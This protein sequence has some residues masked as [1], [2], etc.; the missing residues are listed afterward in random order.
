MAMYLNDRLIDVGW[1]NADLLVATLGM[2]GSLLSRDINDIVARRRDPTRSEYQ[3][4]AAA[5]NERYSDLGHD[6]SVP[7]W[8]DAPPGLG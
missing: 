8:D 4:I 2:S 5:L 6:Y 7:D 3:V 1:T